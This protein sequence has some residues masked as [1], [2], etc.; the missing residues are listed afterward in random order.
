MLPVDVITNLRVLRRARPKL[1]PGDVFTLSPAVDRFLFGRVLLAD[2]P[3]GQAPMPT[4]NLIYIYA[5]EAREPTPA[6]LGQLVPASLL[7]PPQF[8]NRMP[9]TKG[10]FQNVAHEP[11]RRGDLLRQHCFWDSVRKTYRDE[12][13]RVLS[14]RYEPC[15]E[16]AL[17]SYR[18]LDDLVSD[19]LGIERAPGG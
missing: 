12:T 13:G 16:W 14:A 15:G 8:I 17:G 5:A 6:P 10:Y 19:T 18:L 7:L 2:L 1:R 9:W 3:S 11:L 4:A